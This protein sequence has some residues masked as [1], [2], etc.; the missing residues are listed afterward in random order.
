[1]AIKPKKIISSRGEIGVGGGSRGAGGG[2]SAAARRARSNSA[3][4]AKIVA[5]KASI[6]KRKEMIAAQEKLS[7]KEIVKTNPKFQEKIKPVLPSRVLSGRSVKVVP[8][9]NRVR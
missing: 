6:A 5:P 1:M 2:G 7:P 3:A 4:A 8:P 9:R